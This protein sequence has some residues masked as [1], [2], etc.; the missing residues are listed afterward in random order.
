[1]DNESRLWALIDDRTRRGAD[2]A[3]IDRQIWELFGEEWAIVF[4]DLA[5]F[6]RGAERFGIIHFLQVIRESKKLMFP[7]VSDHG[8]V[9]VKSDGDSCMFLFRSPDRALHAAVA[10]QRACASDNER[11]VEEDQ[12]LL[13]AGVGFGRILRIGEQDVWGEEVNA[14]S[15]LGE[16]VARPYDILVTDSVQRACAGIADIRF[17]PIALEAAGSRNNHRAVYDR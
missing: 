2:V 5:G 4:T 1:M 11:R 12:I 10:M 9:L 15:K 16:D 14:A 7:I 13:C 3:A 17:E 6:S 8:G